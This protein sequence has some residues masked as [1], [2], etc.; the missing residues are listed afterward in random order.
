MIDQIKNAPIQSMKNRKLLETT[1][2]CG[3]YSCLEVFDPKLIQQWTDQSQTAICP[4]CGIDS[5]I[6]ETDKKVLE[7]AKKYWF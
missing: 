5:I 3:C 1:K 4:F 2:E 7:A 6:I